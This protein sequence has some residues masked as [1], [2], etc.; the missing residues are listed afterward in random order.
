MVCCTCVPSG[1]G[2]R[3]KT[4]TTH[5]QAD[6][7]SQLSTP[8]PTEDNHHLT[9]VHQLCQAYSIIQMETCYACRDSLIQCVSHIYPQLC[10]G[11]QFVSFDCQVEVHEYILLTD[12]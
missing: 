2:T 4:L 7:P 3:S 10:V 11:Q 8:D 5:T 1:L 6:A 9:S 12:I